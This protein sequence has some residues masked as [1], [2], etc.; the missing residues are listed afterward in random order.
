MDSKK[1]TIFVISGPSGVGKGTVVAQVLKRVENIYLSVSAT[2]RPKR[3]GEN[4][5]VNYFFK[6]KKD[7][8]EMIRAD[9]LLEWAEFTGNYYGT[10]KSFVNNYISSNKDVILEIEVLG[11]KQVKQ[12]CP[13]SILIFLAPPSFKALEERLIN[14]HT[15]TTEMIKLRLNKAKEEMKEINFFNSRVINDKLE[16]AVSDVI[17][18]INTERSKIKG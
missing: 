2:T 10:P 9:E 11:A 16:E 12:K 8:E 4:E 18:I 5:G 3:E 17:S 1:G 7:F 14:R 13:E 6:T 15:E